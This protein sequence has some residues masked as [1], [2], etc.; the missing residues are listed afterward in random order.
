M[1]AKDN[2]KVENPCPSLL[3]RMNKQGDDYFCKS[4]TKTVV[5]FREKSTDEIQRSL[6]KETCG[7]F[8]PEQLTGQPSFGFTRQ[9]RFYFLTVLAFIGFSVKPLSAQVIDTTKMEQKTI[10]LDLKTNDKDTIQVGKSPAEKA[11]HRKELRREKKRGRKKK[12]H[13]VIGTPSF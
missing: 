9:V 2:L 11:K 6:T 7:V 1:K 3:M 12:K 13:R 4:C 10:E 8:H 5:D